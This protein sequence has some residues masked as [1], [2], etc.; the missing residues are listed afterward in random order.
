MKRDTLQGEHRAALVLQETAFSR[1][2]AGQGTSQG[3]TA[4]CKRAGQG[5]SQGTGKGTSLVRKGTGPAGLR[6]SLSGQKIEHD[7]VRLRDVD[8]GRFIPAG[9]PDVAAAHLVQQ[10]HPGAGRNQRVGQGHECAVQRI[11]L[12]CCFDAQQGTCAMAV[13]DD[14][15]HGRRHAVVGHEGH[16]VKGVA[17]EDLHDA[18]GTE[19][20]GQPLRLP[21]RLQPVHVGEVLVVVDTDGWRT[22]QRH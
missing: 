5:T 7:P 19:A 15:R 3:T 14:R 8:R 22:I 1:Q 9:Q 10:Q 11:G 4:S 12:V 21:A 13:H 16:I 2:G 17:A 6:N 18:G 20:T